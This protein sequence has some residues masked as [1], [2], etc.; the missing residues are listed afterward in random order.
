[1]ISAIYPHTSKISNANFTG[2]FLPETK[3]LPHLNDGSPVARE[4]TQ[5]ILDLMMERFDGFTTDATS[6]GGWQNDIGDKFVEPA[7][8]LTVIGENQRYGDARQTVIEIGKMLDQEAM[9]FEVEHFDGIE[10]IPTPLM[11]SGIGRPA[12]AG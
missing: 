9:Y 6:I 5:V 2:F 10:I 7:F 1:M 4:V 3:L 12:N 8:T 11:P